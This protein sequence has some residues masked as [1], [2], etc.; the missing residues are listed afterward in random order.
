MNAYVCTYR[1]K[2]PEPKERRQTEEAA[3]RDPLLRSFL[4]IY[5][6]SY[7]DWGDDPSFFAA[8]NRLGDVRKASWGVCRRDVRNALT[9]GDLVVFFCGCQKKRVWRYYFVG[10]GRVGDLVDR[11]A[12]WT[13]PAQE[14]YR[15]FYN[16]L[17]KVAGGRMFQSETFHPC[18]DDWKR[19]AKAPCVLFDP[20]NSKFNLTS[21]HHVATWD[22]L[23]IPENG[24]EML[25]RRR[26][27]GSCLWSARLIGV[28]EHSVTD[29]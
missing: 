7:Y 23:T 22:G 1:R 19:R 16:V 4:E 21:P 8:Q 6:R 27:N 2:T 17:A 18:H 13:D 15:T 12:L 20:T 28:S 11:A 24:P 9:K 25:A 5:D 10:F 26:S 29:T 3:K 14:P